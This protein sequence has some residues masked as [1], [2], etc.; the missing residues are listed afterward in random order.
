MSKVNFDLVKAKIEDQRYGNSYAHTWARC[1]LALPA[2]EI[3]VIAGIID[4]L[5]WIEQA[6]ELDGALY[7][8][9][10]SY[11]PWLAQERTFHALLA[12]A[13]KMAKTEI[14]RLKAENPD[15][16]PRAVREEGHPLYR[17]VSYASIAGEDAYYAMPNDYYGPGFEIHKDKEGSVTGYFLSR[18]THDFYKKPLAS[19]LL[20]SIFPKL[21]IQTWSRLKSYGEIEITASP[22]VVDNLLETARL[23]DYGAA[24][25][26]CANALIEDFRKEV[27]AMQ[28]RGKPSVFLDEDDDARDWLV[29]AVK[30]GAK[31]IRTQRPDR[32]YDDIQGSWECEL[33]D[34]T[35]LAPYIV[36]RL[37][38]S[39]II[40]PEGYPFQQRNASGD[41]L[42][43]EY[44][45][46]SAKKNF[47]PRSEC[48]PFQAFQS[49]CA[50]R[51]HGDWEECAHPKTCS[52]NCGTENC[53]L[54]TQV[55][56]DDVGE[57]GNTFSEDPAFDYDDWER[58]TMVYSLH[59]N[60]K[61]SF[62]W[63]AAGENAVLALVNTLIYDTY[64]LNVPQRLF[65]NEN[66]KAV[67]QA[68]EEGWL[69]RVSEM[70]G[71]GIV[72]RLSDK[73]IATVEEQIA[74]NKELETA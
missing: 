20:A 16:T 12:V 23:R 40:N 8:R 5:D 51:R 9:V 62:A 57:Y 22:E 34:G 32:E 30:E 45:Q 7:I 48:V 19:A 41:L 39:E 25:Y 44:N 56:S 15:E 70:P 47:E 27:F 43:L 74:K 60:T 42:P 37:Q 66:A 49:Y 35:Q 58:D 6:A 21:G 17:S 13:R 29:S 61:R 2:H 38:N 18:D 33:E 69:T 36:A 10:N 64:S 24:C 50:Y 46:K 73:T 63:K 3:R 1:D 28:W 11:S 52:D 26:K 67:K 4:S 53:P 54:V 31:I 72:A 55:Y 65:G 71:L 59:P 68:I 14:N